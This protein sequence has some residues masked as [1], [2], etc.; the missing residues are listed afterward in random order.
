MTTNTIDSS[1]L[2]T[3]A[4]VDTCIPGVACI[5]FCTRSLYRNLGQ[6]STCPPQPSRNNNKLLSPLEVSPVTY[7]LG[8]H[9]QPPPLPNLMEA[10]SPITLSSCSVCTQRCLYFIND[11]HNYI[12][13]IRLLAFNTQALRPNKHIIPP[14]YIHLA[15]QPINIIK[16]KQGLGL[17]MLQSPPL[18]FALSSVQLIY[19]TTTR[20]PKSSK[21]CGYS[22]C[23]ASSCSYVVYYVSI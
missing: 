8:P 12:Y 1:V 21:R 15:H 14:T 13:K 23:I 22:T 18:I 17:G 7:P 4:Q 6:H 5:S 2:T 10:Q 9:N 11:L 16:I 3:C 19:T 20:F